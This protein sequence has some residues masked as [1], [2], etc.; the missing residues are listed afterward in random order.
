MT[1]LKHAIEIDR[2]IEDVYALAKQ[3]ER[4]PEFMKDYLTSQIVEHSPDGDVVERS[5]MVKGKLYTWKSRVSY[6]ENEG[7]YFVHQE[8]PLHGMQ[9][10]WRFLELTPERTR[11]TI[12]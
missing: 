1:Q 12:T 8:G 3:V 5:A 6:Q 7:V 2:P 11:L 4:Y 10:S 9:V